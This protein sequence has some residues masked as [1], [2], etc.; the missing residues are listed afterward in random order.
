MKRVVL[1]FGIFLMIV[2][3]VAQ[4]SVPP[5]QG[6]GS[7]ANPYQIAIW[8]NLYWLSETAT[9]WDKNYFQ[10]ADIDFADADPAINTWDNNQGWTPIGNSYRKFT[11]KYNGNN[12]TI[13]GLFIYR[14]SVAD[15]GFFGWSDNAG[16]ENIGLI[17]VNLAGSHRSGSLAAH[18]SD[19]NI[20]HCYS[21]GMI[22]GNP[23][24]P[25]DCLGGM[26]GANLG[27]SIS[28]SYSSVCV[29]GFGGSV[30]YC[31]S[32]GNVSGTIYIGGLVGLNT[33]SISHSYNTG[34]VN[35]SE[36]T[37]GLAGFNAG[38]SI[39][40]CYSTGNVNGNYYTGGLIGYNDRGIINNSYSIGDVHGLEQDT[41]GLTGR[42][43]QGLFTNCYSAGHVTGNDYTGGLAGVNCDRINNCFW[44]IETSGQTTSA[45]GTGITTLQMKMQLTYINAGWNFSEVWG[46]IPNLNNGYPFLNYSNSVPAEDIIIDSPQS[47]FATLY[48]AYP[49]PFN[50]STTI[51]FDLKNHEEVKINI[52]NIKGHLVKRLVNKVYDKGRYSVIWDGKDSQGT[53][54]GNGIYFFQ[55]LTDNT[56]QTKK[57][58]MMK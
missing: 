52:Y 38:D 10:T 4:M 16:F 2:G 50:P 31:Y 20:S 58:I 43:N 26:T 53:P 32:T 49:N 51:S 36:K 23:Y 30:S 55:M 18:N 42:N 37:G 7:V 5:A 1:F 21:T 25:V 47:S 46:I 24:Y 13:S 27:G 41:G 29:K 17:N 8:Q 44:D 48:S 54:C 40:I 3:L 56:I 22:S 57:M 11:G 12:K 28:H 14:P 19:C 34:N 15:Q 39:M 9:E 33:G 45:G 35:G 6:D